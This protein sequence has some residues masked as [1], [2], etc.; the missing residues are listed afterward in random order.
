MD[1]TYPIPTRIA[2]N[3]WINSQQHEVF[4]QKF[5]DGNEGFWAE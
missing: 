1:K 5:I 3:A 4:Y 2:E